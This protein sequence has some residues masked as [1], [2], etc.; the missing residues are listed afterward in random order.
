[1]LPVFPEKSSGC[2]NK[3]LYETILVQQKNMWKNKTSTVAWLSPRKN[4]ISSLGEEWWSLLLKTLS[5]RKRERVRLGTPSL[6]DPI[7]DLSL[8]AVSPS[9]RTKSLYRYLTFDSYI[10]SRADVF[11]E[12]GDD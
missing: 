8:W 3:R 7:Q 10:V 12:N 1:M 9:D 4:R 5:R 2:S 6:I 11:S